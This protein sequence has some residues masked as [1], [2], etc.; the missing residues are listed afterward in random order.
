MQSKF[1]NQNFPEY[2]NKIHEIFLYLWVINQSFIHV[3]F[4]KSDFFSFYNNIH[5][6]KIG[7]LLCS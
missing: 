4:P 5:V 3:D 7:A 6:I 2:L 1:Q